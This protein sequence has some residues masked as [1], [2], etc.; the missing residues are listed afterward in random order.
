MPWLEATS[1][2]TEVLIGAVFDITLNEADS[3]DQWW[4]WPAADYEAFY[5]SGTYSA[6]TVEASASGVVELSA[7]LD[8]ALDSSG[9]FLDGEV[10]Q[11]QPLGENASITLAD[12]IDSSGA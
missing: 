1:G 7:N 8:A 12:P 4:I 10:V 6:E 9:Q 3:W 11:L 5:E 2:G